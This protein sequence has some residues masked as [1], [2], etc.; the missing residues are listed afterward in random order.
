MKWFLIA[1]MC[2]PG[3]GEQLCIRMHSDFIYDS[4]QMC[5]EKRNEYF[6]KLGVVATE[7]KG[8]FS[9]RCTDSYSI[10]E[11]IGETE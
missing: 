8:H 1:T 3:Y 10:Q 11:F 4:S 2:L 7:Y 5:I 9:I 6:S